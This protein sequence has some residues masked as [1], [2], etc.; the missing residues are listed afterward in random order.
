VNEPTRWYIRDVAAFLK[1]HPATVTAYKSRGQIVE[2]D[3]VIDKT[4]P[5]WY[6]KT[7]RDWEATRASARRHHVDQEATG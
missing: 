1:V 2:P 5:W 3:G 4:K 7:I 6:E